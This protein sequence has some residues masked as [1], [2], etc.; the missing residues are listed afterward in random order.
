MDKKREYGLDL[1]RIVSMFMVVILHSLNHGGL[2]EGALVPGTLN[3]YVC[4]IVYALCFVAVN[5]FV[6]ISGYFLCTAKFSFKKIIL[7]WFEAVFYSV[8]G[9]L[10]SVA[11]TDMMFSV[12]ELIKSF[13]V[14]TLK[15][16]WFFTAYVLL[17][18]SIPFLNAAI[19]QLN[20][21]THLMI[22]SSSLLIFS[23][24]HN[25][26]FISDFGGVAGG[27]SFLW[28]CILYLLAAYMRFYV[29]TK[30]KIQKLMLPMYF[31]G[32]LI[33]AGER[34]LA[35]II[36]PMIFKRVVL[37]SL[38]FSYNSIFCVFGSMCIFQ[39][40]RGIEIKVCR[41]QKAINF[42]APLTFAVYLIHD[43][44]N[45]REMIWNCFGLYNYAESSFLILY[46]IVISILIFSVCCLIEK[47]RKSI[48]KR[49]QVA[50][51]VSLSCDK[52]QNW[53]Y[54]KFQEIH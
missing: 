43:Q 54:S 16:Y 20:K 24:L 31:I 35:Y 33:V 5:C 7:L 9:F 15:R 8:L 14:F 19:K 40:F 39:Y 29:P 17:Y 6:M 12:T 49:I 30:I 26:V 34:F 21:T 1:L 22:V 13:M 18:V 28:F 51:Y 38:F 47:I 11:S 25:V 50:K 42:V 45:I 48:T 44:K 27:Y 23:F 2:V 46:I 4:N 37:D 53:V 10:V 41:I 3:F 36:T 52:I 32:C